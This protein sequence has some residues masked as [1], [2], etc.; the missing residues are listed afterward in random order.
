MGKRELDKAR[1]KIDG[2]DGKIITLLA[3]RVSLVKD[4]AKY[5]KLHHKKILDLNRT[6]QVLREKQKLAKELNLD[7]VLVNNIF[8]KILEDSVKTQE[9]IKKHRG[10]KDTRNEIR[11]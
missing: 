4:I 9:L 1:K 11:N 6:K 10:L 2:I 3:K 8:K 5:K 7:V